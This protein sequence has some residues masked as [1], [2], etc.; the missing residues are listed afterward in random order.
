MQY[1]RTVG[2]L[3][4]LVILGPL[5]FVAA[6]CAASGAGA[7]EDLAGT[8]DL[9]QSLEDEG[10]TLLSAGFAGELQFSTTG[11]AF[12]VSRGGTLHVYEYDNAEQASLDAMRV[13]GRFG[14]SVD[15]FQSG[16][17]IAVYDGNNLSVRNALS[18]L[19]GPQLY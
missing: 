17:L 5:A 3:T 9:V 16:R 10:I 8:S 6:G 14:S 19:M 7:G 15:I 18:K 11:Q 2:Y 1:R 4:T 13:D 12:D